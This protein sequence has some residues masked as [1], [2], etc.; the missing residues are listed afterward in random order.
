V[1]NYGTISELYLKIA[2]DIEGSGHDVIG[3]IAQIFHS[4][5][6]LSQTNL[7]SSGHIF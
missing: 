4:L 5:S 6:S 1:P 3:A 2:R 7:W